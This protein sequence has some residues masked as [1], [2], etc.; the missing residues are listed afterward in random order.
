M[1]LFRPQRCPHGPTS[2]IA[3]S[4]SWLTEPLCPAFLPDTSETAN[5]IS[6]E[7]PFLPLWLNLEPAPGS[8]GAVQSA[9]SRCGCCCSPKPLEGTAGPLFLPASSGAPLRA[10]SRKSSSSSSEGAGDPPPLV[11]LS[12]C[13]SQDRGALPGPRGYTPASRPLSGDKGGVGSSLG[14]GGGRQ[15]AYKGGS[16]RVLEAWGGVFP[17]SKA[18]W[19]TKPPCDPL[20]PSGDTLFSSVFFSGH[21]DIFFSKHL[22]F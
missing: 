13:K 2:L 10:A 9:D 7:S 22:I 4:W 3:R 20:L 21:L 8:A 6:D 14:R 19:V 16:V 15:Q 17:V 1:V 11:S 18:V 12:S 5:G